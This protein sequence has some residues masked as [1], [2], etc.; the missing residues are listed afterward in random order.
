MKV[1]GDDGKYILL[2]PLGGRDC[3]GDEYDGNVSGYYWSS[4]LRRNGYAVHF[5]FGAEAAIKNIDGI[6]SVYYSPTCEGFPVHLVLSDTHDRNSEVQE[7]VDLGLPSG[8][9]WKTY[10]EKGYYDYDSASRKFGDSVPTVQQWEELKRCCKWAW[11]GNG[12]KITGNNGKCIILPA[13]GNDDGLGYD[14]VGFS[15]YYWANKKAS[16]DVYVIQFNSEDFKCYEVS[17]SRKLSVRLVH[18]S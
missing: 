4:S 2:P 5:D 3:A 18:N 9:L 1:T 11:K 10:N 16:E 14:L 7:Y 17:S 12:Y 13:M 8:T 6:A 15:G